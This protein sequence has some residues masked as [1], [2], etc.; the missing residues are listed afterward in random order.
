MLCVSRGWKRIKGSGRAVRVCVCVRR[1]PEQVDEFGRF[2]R[3]TDA[4]RVPL[5]LE[6]LQTRRVLC[7]PRDD[8]VDVVALVEAQ[9]PAV[10]CPEYTRPTNNRTGSIIQSATVQNT[11]QSIL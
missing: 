4:V 10:C 1:P 11:D 2:V 8:L 7:K 3:E 6:R 9:E 5:D